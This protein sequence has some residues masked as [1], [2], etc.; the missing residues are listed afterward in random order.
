M[1]ILLRYEAAPGTRGPGGGC[2]LFFE[3][4]EYQPLARASASAVAITITPVG[5]GWKAS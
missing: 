3:R 4:D 5:V 1:S 2:L